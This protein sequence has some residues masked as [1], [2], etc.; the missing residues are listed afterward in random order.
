M[1]IGPTYRRSYDWA[2]KSRGVFFAFFRCFVDKE[3]N[4]NS[5]VFSERS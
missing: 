2:M 1:Q 3:W 5:F 4:W